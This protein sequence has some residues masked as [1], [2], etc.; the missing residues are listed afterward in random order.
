MSRTN[1]FVSSGRTS[2]FVQPHGEGFLFGYPLIGADRKYYGPITKDGLLYLR[3]T[4]PDYP[5]Q[6]GTLWIDEVT[7]EEIK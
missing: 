4:L 7:C 2:A 1:V 6:S 5:E 3:I